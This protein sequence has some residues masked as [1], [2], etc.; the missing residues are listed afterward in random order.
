MLRNFRSQ[1]GAFG[2]FYYITGIM[3]PH[4][5][6]GKIVPFIRYKTVTVK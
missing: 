2:G 4:P 5:D 6:T 3:K 1:N